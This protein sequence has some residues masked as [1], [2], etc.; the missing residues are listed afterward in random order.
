MLPLVKWTNEVTSEVYYG[1][2][3]LNLCLKTILLCGKAAAGSWFPLQSFRINHTWT[4]NK[5][6]LQL[7]ITNDNL[8]HGN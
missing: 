4:R 2:V 3:S 8:S 1:S 7:R 6:T 5:D